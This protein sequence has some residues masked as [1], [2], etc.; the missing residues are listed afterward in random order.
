M[1]DMVVYSQHSKVLG[2]VLSSAFCVELACSV[3]HVY[4]FSRFVDFLKTYM[5]G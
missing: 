4:I 1:D 2:L 3:L 5:L